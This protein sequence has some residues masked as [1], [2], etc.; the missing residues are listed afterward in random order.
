MYDFDHSLFLALNFD[1]G[2][3]V[4]RL[5]LLLSGAATWTPFYL[6]TLWLVVRRY[7]WRGGA[8]WLVAAAL[9]VGLSDMICGIFKLNGPLGDLLPGFSPRWRPMYTPSLEGLAVPPDTL[10]MWRFAGHATPGAVHVPE[11]AL[12]GFYGT[13]SAHMATFAALGVLSAA[14][15]RR[16]W[17]TLL[18]VAVAL[19]VGY[20]RIYLAKH[21]PMDLAWGA[22]TGAVVGA[23]GYLL[24]RRLLDRVQRHR[25]A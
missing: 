2:P 14:V 20:T 15:V 1:G 9:A 19:T 17:F 18:T 24:F 11:G 25:G 10:V 7:G 5:M 12:G 23:G 13:V 4:D 6:L 21:F 16:R 8:L 3:V 22:L